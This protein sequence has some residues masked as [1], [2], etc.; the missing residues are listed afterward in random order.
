MVLNPD[1]K[2]ETKNTAELVAYSI[3]N[4]IIEIRSMN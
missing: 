1:R 2:A 3:I 4:K